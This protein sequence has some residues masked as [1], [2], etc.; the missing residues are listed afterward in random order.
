MFA[1]QRRDVS[2]FGSYD[3]LI[4]EG[5]SL[6]KESRVVEDCSR[7]LEGT[8]RTEPPKITRRE[9]R[10]FPFDVS[11]KTERGTRYREAGWTPAFEAE[12]NTTSKDK[13][14]RVSKIGRF[15]KHDHVRLRT[16]IIVSRAMTTGKRTNFVGEVF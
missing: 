12:R 5:I 13:G 11:R 1:E 16:I 2:R 9:T 10:S 4:D 8:E 7:V 15:E 6:C 3:F 14:T